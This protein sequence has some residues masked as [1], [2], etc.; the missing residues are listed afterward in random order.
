MHW[1]WAIGVG[2]FWIVVMIE[3][4]INRT[5][6]Y[7]K[8]LQSTDE[9]QALVNKVKQA[10]PGFEFTIQ[11]YHYETRSVSDGKN[12]RTETVRVNTHFARMAY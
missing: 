8:N 1:G 2:C 4:F 12:S 9:C 10:A 7:F 5:F 11:N 6:W 3:T